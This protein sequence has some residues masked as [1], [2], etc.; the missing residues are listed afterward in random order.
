MRGANR[1]AF[2]AAVVTLI[3]GIAL[4][5]ARGHELLVEQGWI[6]AL[7]L[8]VAVSLARNLAPPVVSRTRRWLPWRRRP[9]TRVLPEAVQ[10]LVTLVELGLAGEFELHYRV[11]PVLVEAAA[12]RLRH[13][14][15]LDLATDPLAASA[16]L[17]PQAWELLRPDRPEP[18]ERGTRG[19]GA[20]S[21]RS[22]LEALEG[23]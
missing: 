13:R 1:P 23:L 3:A 15:G 21:I 16:A 20:A 9:E 18:P 17:G 6:V 19:D 5:A 22:V 4:A 10:S 7:S 14:R 12:A 2:V 8:I 11:R